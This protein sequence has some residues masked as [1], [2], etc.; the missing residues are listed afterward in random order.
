MPV[1]SSK[2]TDA[3]KLL[4]K[5]KKL[6]F[7]KHFKNDRLANVAVWPDLAIFYKILSNLGSTFWLSSKQWDQIGRFLATN[8]FTKVAQVFGDYWAV[9]K[10]SLFIKKTI[11]ATSGTTGQLFIS[12]YGHTALIS[13]SLLMEK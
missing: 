11:M 5:N 2:Q 6:C 1:S 3:L 12:T 4:F 10:K 13:I 8:F 9:S 7:I